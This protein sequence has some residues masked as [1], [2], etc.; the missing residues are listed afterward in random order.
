MVNILRY[1][2]TGL[3]LFALIKAATFFEIFQFLLLFLSLEVLLFDVDLLLQ[4]ITQS[5]LHL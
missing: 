3:F 4:Y 5:F 2:K 1:L